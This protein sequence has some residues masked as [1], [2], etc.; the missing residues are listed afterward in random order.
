MTRQKICTRPYCWEEPGRAKCSKIQ[1][2]EMGEE[3]TSGG[4]WGGGKKG[5]GSK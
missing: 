1:S 2:A 4:F 5:F 3:P